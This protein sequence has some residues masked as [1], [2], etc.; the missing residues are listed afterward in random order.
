VIILQEVRTECIH[1][2]ELT[3]CWTTCVL[4]ATSAALAHLIPKKQIAQAGNDTHH[5][6][7]WPFPAVAAFAAAHTD[8]ERTQ[9]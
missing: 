2:Q 4:I 1:V 9:Q 3:L 7:C 5:S 8:N 6:R